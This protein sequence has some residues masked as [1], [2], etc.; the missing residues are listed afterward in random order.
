MQ[1]IALIYR[2]RQCG[3]RFRG[4][5]GDLGWQPAPGFLGILFGK[6]RNVAT[7]P[8]ARPTCPRCGSTDAE[9]L[10]PD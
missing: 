7:L 3:K 6:R 2:C 10:V 5:Q 1:S 8:G 4:S 9:S